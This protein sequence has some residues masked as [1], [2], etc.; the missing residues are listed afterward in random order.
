MNRVKDYIQFAVCFAG[1]GY[2]TLWPL[3]AHDG[4]IAAFEA[5]LICSDRFLADA[6]CRLPQPMTLS[7]GLHLAGLL[8]ATAVVARCA[9]WRL[10]RLLHFRRAVPGD[11]ARVI[12]RLRILA[13]A[14]SPASMPIRRAVKPRRQFGLRGLPR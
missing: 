14:G 7:P 6:I 13:R 5:S 10:A 9:W 3:T 12:S 8:A 2:V 1:L 11:T 4:P